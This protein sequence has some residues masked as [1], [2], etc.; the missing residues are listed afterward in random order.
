[1]WTVSRLVHSLEASP[2][3]AEFGD[4]QRL[5]FLSLDLGLTDLGQAGF[6][7]IYAL[8]SSTSTEIAWGYQARISLS[9]AAGMKW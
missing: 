3:S 6:V 4:R 5:V 2:L 1:M 9:V 7:C 8:C